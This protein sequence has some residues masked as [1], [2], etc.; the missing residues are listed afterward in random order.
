MKFAT[1]QW[2]AAGVFLW[3]CAGASQAKYVTGGNPASPFVK[4]CDVLN[5]VPLLSSST[6]PTS[7]GAAP[8]ATGQLA[9]T[10]WAATFGQ[11][12]SV[13]SGANWIGS[14]RQI[15]IAKFIVAFKA[16]FLTVPICIVNNNAYVPTVSG[17]STSAENTTVSQVLVDLSLDTAREGMGP[18]FSLVCTVGQ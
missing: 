1:L 9:G 18:L 2:L 11:H 8:A 5:A 6:N 4:G 13:L 10:V 17:L 12:G 16:N 7:C 3:L 15:E 14:A